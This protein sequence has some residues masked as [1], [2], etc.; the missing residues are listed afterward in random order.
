MG[1]QT[2]PPFESFTGLGH[3]LAHFLGET[4]IRI[5]RAVN[6]TE[7]FGTVS[8]GVARSGSTVA[9]GASASPRYNPLQ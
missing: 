5:A 7:R 6:D 2:M 8:G 4:E 1:F 9:R 3:V